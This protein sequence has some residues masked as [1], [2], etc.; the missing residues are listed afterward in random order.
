MRNLGGLVG[1]LGLALGAGLSFSALAQHY[2]AQ[3]IRVI[4]GFAPGGAT[5]IAARAVGQKLS[6]ALKQSV[7]IDNR[8][9]ASGNIAADLTAKEI[10]K[11]AKVVKMAGIKPQ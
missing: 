6:E 9:G 10:P 4:V 1:M 5:D 8:P 3:P 7:V 2:P 11:W